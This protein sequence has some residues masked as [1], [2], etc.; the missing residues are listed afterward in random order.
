MRF[1]ENFAIVP[2]AE[3]ADWQSAGVDL[4]SVNMGLLHS[5]CALIQLG[6]ITGN[7]TVIK[8]YGGATSGAKTTA[9]AFKYR[10]SG[11]DQGSA[12]DDQFG[13]LSAAVVAAT[14]LVFTDSGD[15]NLRTIAIEIDS[16]EM[17]AGL[18]WLTIEIDDG[19]ASALLLSAQGIGVP[20]YKAN[21]VITVV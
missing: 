16:D 7:D 12:G 21:D 11:A 9:I 4:R 2:L 10:L 19:S 14:G 15:Y 3:P 18:P 6:A 20:R 17:P 1:T 5:F 8:A 13:D